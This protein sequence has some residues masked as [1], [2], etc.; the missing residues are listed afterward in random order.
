MKNARR[1][2]S[3]SAPALRSQQLSV[4]EDGRSR[5]LAELRARLA[6]AE[7][8]LRAIRSGEVDALVVTGRQGEQIYT[9]Q[10]TDHAYQT[11][12]ESMNEG[13]VTLLPDGV[14]LYANQCFARLV[15]R[16]LELVI[17]SAFHRF[18]SGS[19]RVTLATLLKRVGRRGAKAEVVL[20][21]GDGAGVPVRISICPFGPDHANGTD[22]C[23][24]VT[25]MTEARRN[26]G[27]LRDLTHRLMQSQETER[28]RVANDLRVNIT[29]LLYVIL[30]RSEALMEKVPAGDGSAI[31]VRTTI[32]EML[33]K[34]AEEVD[35]I[36]RGLWSHEL[37]K[38]G[39]V[40]ALEKA[41]A[42]FME[43]TGVSIQMD[44]PP[45]AE[46]LP[47]EAK[48]AFYRILQNALNNVEQHARARHVNVRLT[49]P[50]TCVQLAIQD[51]GIG[52]KPDKNLAKQVEKG[53][54]GLIQM[55]ER[56]A[57]V[58]GVLSVK[59]APRAGTEIAV[60]I[61]LRS[62]APQ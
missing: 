48:L 46:L 61:P 39:L 14:I 47:P 55:R 8:T 40:S 9:L 33:R 15:A 57:Y 5:E 24:V 43:R 58:G 53:G 17:G 35:R 42:E 16:P 29:Q 62:N 37:E 6:E 27:V 23:L 60:S 3:R 41:G 12:V 54:F 10:S 56:A 30:G 19:D 1:Q 59:S 13:A 2:P 31:G 21:T 4:A 36:W 20:Q 44:C 52:F 7:E 34:T 26:E 45:L 51:D 50:G 18:L 25:D 28:G 32:N 38:L 49:Q 11:L 22:L